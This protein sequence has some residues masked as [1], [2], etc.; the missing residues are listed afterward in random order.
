MNEETLTPT[1]AAEAIGLAFQQIAVEFGGD[2]ET[3]LN[4][5]ATQVDIVLDD[6]NPE[7]GFQYARVKIERYDPSHPTDAYPVESRL[8]DAVAKILNPI[9]DGE[10]EVTQ[11]PT[12]Q[13]RMSTF[14]RTLMPQ[15]ELLSIETSSQKPNES[16]TRW[17]I[18]NRISLNL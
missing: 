17:S 14:Y 2:V 10:P 15:I 11:L 6:T 16:V 4:R 18:S 9:Q 12:G 1:H 5:R 13:T 3:D 7:T 8:R